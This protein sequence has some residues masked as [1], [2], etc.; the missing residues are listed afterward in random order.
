LITQHQPDR[1]SATDP[2]CSFP[3]S[4]QRNPNNGDAVIVANLL[5]EYHRKLKEFEQFDADHDGNLT[6]AELETGLRAQQKSDREIKQM[7]E[8][9]ELNE[10]GGVGPREYALMSIAV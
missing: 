8:R 5:E 6:E 2:P 4:P 10:Q 7:W 1:A 3:L 9:L